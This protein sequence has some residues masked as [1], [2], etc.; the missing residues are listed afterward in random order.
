MGH[1]EIYSLQ[2]WLTARL[3]LKNNLQ[4]AELPQFGLGLMQ[5]GPTF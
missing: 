5:H 3:R 1:S 4:L 2:L